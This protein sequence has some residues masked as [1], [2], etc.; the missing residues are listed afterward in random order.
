[1]E[2]MPEKIGDMQGRWS[3]LFKTTQLLLLPFGAFTV[4]WMVW[5][6][7][8]VVALK[9]GVIGNYTVAMASSDARQHAS[10]HATAHGALT[11][12]LAT[13]RRELS[14]FRVGLSEMPPRELLDRV[15]RLEMEIRALKDKGE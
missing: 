4:G 12:E 6:S 11:Q 10:L 3:L 7:T 8:E 14:S 1:M 15:T 2:P 5:L 9:V 13:L